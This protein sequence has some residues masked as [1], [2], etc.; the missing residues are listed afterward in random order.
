MT[1]EFDPLAPRDAF[2]FLASGNV[3][4]EQR[5]S[6]SERRSLIESTARTLGMTE[7][8]LFANVSLIAYRDGVSEDA[9]LMTMVE[10]AATYDQRADTSVSHCHD[11][12]PADSCRAMASSA[13][14]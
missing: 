9:A 4:G 2:G 14:A 1:Y 7:P 6:P 8:M 10:Y 12:T 13:S 5:L 3:W 11:N